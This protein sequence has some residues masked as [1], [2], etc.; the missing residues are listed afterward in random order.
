MD[1]KIWLTEYQVIGRHLPTEANPAP[2]LYRMRIFAPNDVV[3]KSRFWYFLMKLRKV[4]KANG[5]IVSVNVGVRFVTFLSFHV[6]VVG[7][8]VATADLPR[9]QKVLLA[10]AVSK[11]VPAMAEEESSSSSSSSSSL[12]PPPIPT[13]G[14]VVTSLVPAEREALRELLLDPERGPAA[15]DALLKHTPIKTVVRIAP[16]RNTDM[17]HMRDSWVKSVTARMLDARTRAKAE[18]KPGSLPTW[19]ADYTDPALDQSV[20]DLKTLGLGLR[21][22]VPKGEAVML[23]RGRDGALQ[24][25]TQPPNRLA[26]PVAWLGAVRDERVSRVLW[27]KYLAGKT[28]ASEEARQ[29]IIAGMM[30]LVKRPSGVIEQRVV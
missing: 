29:S 14:P 6:Y 13:A 10:A 3:A 21:K 11:A 27:A 7:M 18:A 9:L 25:L 30:D 20:I 19:L 12:T 2:K 24:L 1:D 22:A 5:E 28:V 26:G 4:K 23:L 16:T 17:A 8:Y 15:W